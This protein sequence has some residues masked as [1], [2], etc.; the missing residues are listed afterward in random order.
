VEV[1]LLLKVVCEEVVGR[2]VPED[3]LSPRDLFHR[4]EHAKEDESGEK[5]GKAAGC[6]TLTPRSHGKHGPRDEE[7]PER[8][9][10]EGLVLLDALVVE[11]RVASLQPRKRA[12]E[13]QKNQVGN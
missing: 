2:T 3:A 6:P 8:G 13:A 7:A 10:L 5:P 12:E 1:E 4:H 9:P 11:L